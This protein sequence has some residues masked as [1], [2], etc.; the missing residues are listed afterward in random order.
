MEQ[1]GRGRGRGRG[2]S[3]GKGRPRGRRAKKVC[4]YCETKTEP[5]YKAHETLSRIVS[6][7]GKI[8]PRRINGMCAKHQRRVAV[9]VKR[10]RYLGLLPFVA[11]NIR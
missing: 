1:R 6:E 5:D 2:R 11:E 8:L 10:A 9:S 4:I 3:R 7:R